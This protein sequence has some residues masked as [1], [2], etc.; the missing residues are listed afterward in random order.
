MEEGRIING[1][2]F[3]AVVELVLLIMRNRES[4]RR[5]QSQ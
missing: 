5:R 1:Q 4:G 3:N 2:A